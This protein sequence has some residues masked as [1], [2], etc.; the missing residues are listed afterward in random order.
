M[1]TTEMTLPLGQK[2]IQISLIRLCGLWQL[3]AKWVS[4]GSILDNEI[5]HKL[6]FYVNIGII[7]IE[8]KI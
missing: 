4:R 8:L 2:I 7:N 1:G 5:I 6:D 3:Q